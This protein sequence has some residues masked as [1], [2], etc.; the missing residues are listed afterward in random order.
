MF[1]SAG[2]WSLPCTLTG[3]A[4]TCQQGAAPLCGIPSGLCCSGHPPS[5]DNFPLTGITRSGGHCFQAPALKPWRCVYPQK[6]HGQTSRLDC[7]RTGNVLRLSV[8]FTTK[9]GRLE[10]KCSS[11]S[12]FAGHFSLLKD[13]F[14]PLPALGAVGNSACARLMQALSLAVHP[15]KGGSS[16][17]GC[18]LH[19]FS[20]VQGLGQ[21]PGADCSCLP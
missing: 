9:A 18:T 13:T 7:L 19:C 16:G 17:L 14:L 21:I 15:C 3:S 10:T 1:L 8:L 12:A 20:L 11:S 6:G 5:S 4:C 2:P